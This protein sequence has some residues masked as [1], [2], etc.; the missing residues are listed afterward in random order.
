VYDDSQG[1][2]GYVSLEV[3]P[4]LARHTEQTMNEARK[5]FQLVD[6]PNV[7]IKI[8]GTQEGLTA[9]EQMLYEGVNI[10]ITLLFSIQRYEEVAQ[11]YI[12]AMQRRAGE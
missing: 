2:D 11:A 6:R 9:I 7:F 12:R 8:P 3:S 10:N 4:R 1:V 5:F